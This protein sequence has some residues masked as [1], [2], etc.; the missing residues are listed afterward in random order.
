MA[1]PADIA[2][3]RKYQR[4]NAGQNPTYRVCMALEQIAD[5]LE[6]IRLDLRE[7][8]QAKEAGGDSK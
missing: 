5:V 2:A 8:V 3:A 6:C 4:E 7:L 1:E